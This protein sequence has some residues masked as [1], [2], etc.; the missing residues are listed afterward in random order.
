M[1]FPRKLLNES[2]DIVLDLRPHWWFLA[3]PIFFLVLVVA[4]TAAVAAFDLADALWLG[5]LGL[6]ALVLLWLGARFLK[7]T[8]TNFVVTT[9]RLIYRS[10]VIA[11]QG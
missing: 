11:K 7:W 6:T 2:E 5:G 9:D 1:P 8:T 4:A 3:R 10:G